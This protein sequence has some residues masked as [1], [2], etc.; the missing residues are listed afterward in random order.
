MFLLTHSLGALIGAAF[1][2]DHQDAV[3]G[4]VVSGPL[5]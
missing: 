1:L 2:L 4:A 3:S 5:V